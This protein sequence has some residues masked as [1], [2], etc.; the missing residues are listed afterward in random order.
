MAFWNQSDIPAI[1][2]ESSLFLADTLNDEESVATVWLK[3]MLVG[4]EPSGTF[5]HSSEQVLV[6]GCDSRAEFIDGL[7]NTFHGSTASFFDMNS[8]TVW[9][10]EVENPHMMFIGHGLWLIDNDTL[11]KCVTPAVGVDNFKLCPPLLIH[12][13][14][15]FG[16]HPV[17]T[18]VRIETNVGLSMIGSS[19]DIIHRSGLNYEPI[20][21]LQAR[22]VERWPMFYVLAG[23]AVA[24][25]VATANGELDERVSEM[26]QFIPTY[27]DKRGALTIDR[28]RGKAP[29]WHDEIRC[30]ECNGRV[31]LKFPRGN[32]TVD[33][34]CP[35]SLTNPP[36]HDILFPHLLDNRTFEEGE[37]GLENVPK[38]AS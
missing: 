18:I 23:M 36:L 38:E 1:I 29:V 10:L 15:A 13:S 28:T 37:H 17:G 20:N 33:A 3:S 24:C 12:D 2:Q 27:R 14:P 16:H 11:M 30:Q 21:T 32:Q 9:N 35:H 19:G 4:R 34:K 5:L 31:V 6:S 8:E 25:I 7:A 22:R 26:P